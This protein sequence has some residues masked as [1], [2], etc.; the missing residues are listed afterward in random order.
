MNTLKT[1]PELMT[2]ICNIQA[3]EAKINNGN[4]PFSKLEKM[5]SD[6]LY[7]RQNELIPFYNASL[8]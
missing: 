7:D 2:V 5:N 1:N 4:T 3:M 6:Q 8:K